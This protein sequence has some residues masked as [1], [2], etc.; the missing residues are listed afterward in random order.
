MFTGEF[1]GRGGLSA[2]EPIGVNLAVE[3]FE[4][5]RVKPADAHADKSNTTIRVQQILRLRSMITSLP[6]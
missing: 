3:P 5:I 1:G 6:T 2:V 4:P